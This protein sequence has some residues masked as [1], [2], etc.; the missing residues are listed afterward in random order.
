MLININNNFWSIK[1]SYIINLC[2]FINNDI[3]IEYTILFYDKKEFIIL[4]N[5]VDVTSLP[6]NVINEPNLYLKDYIS[7]NIILTNN[8]FDKF[9]KVINFEYKLIKT[10]NDVLSRLPSLTNE[11]YDLLNYNGDS[12]LITEIRFLFK[13]KLIYK[14]FQ[15]D[16]IPDF[17][18]NNQY[19]YYPYFNYDSAASRFVFNASYC[20]NAGTYSNT[21][22][23]FYLPNKELSDYIGKQFINELTK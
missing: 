14:V 22:V 1:E 13:I 7:E 3:N 6:I 23:R 9:L 11:E 10:F 19:K 18:D 15:Q 12:K 20:V 2:E 8:Y 21:G 5:N 16:F 4:N 17:S